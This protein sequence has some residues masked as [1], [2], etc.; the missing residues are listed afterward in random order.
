MLICKSKAKKMLLYKKP[1]MQKKP[2][3]KYST[4]LTLHVS[5]NEAMK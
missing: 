1:R 4:T 2:L 3:T 5:E